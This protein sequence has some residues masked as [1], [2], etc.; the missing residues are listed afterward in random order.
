[1]HAATA[2]SSLTDAA[3]RE[4]LGCTRQEFAAL[5]PW[6]QRQLRLAAG[7]SVDPVSRGL[8]HGGY[9]AMGR[10]PADDYDWRASGAERIAHSSLAAIAARFEHPHLAARNPMPMASGWQQGATR[11]AAGIGSTLSMLSPNARE[12]DDAVSSAKIV[13]SPS[14]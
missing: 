7:L 5:P 9:V 11:N 10:Q 6:K 8:L 13:Q 12:Q 2:E 4:S 1:M 3:F 14:P